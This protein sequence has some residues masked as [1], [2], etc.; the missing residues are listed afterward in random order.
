MFF[1]TFQLLGIAFY[2]CAMY[3]LL[4]L[5]STLIFISSICLMKFLKGAIKYS[6]CAHRLITLFFNC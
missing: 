1:Y 4:L 5:T 6:T 2:N 3:R